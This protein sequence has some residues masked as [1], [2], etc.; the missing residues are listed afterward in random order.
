[1]L[2]PAT[3]QRLTSDMMKA[4]AQRA[5]D[6]GPHTQGNTPTW[7]QSLEIFYG[8]PT[9]TWN[10][11]QSSIELD[12][13][14]P[15]GVDNGD[16]NVTVKTLTSAGAIG[17]FDPTKGTV[18]GVGNVALGTTVSTD[19][20]V[21]YAY[22]DNGDAFIVGAPQQR[23]WDTR[24]SASGNGYLEILILQVKYIW[25]WAD[26]DSEAGSWINL[27]T[28]TGP[29]APGGMGMV[30]FDY[31]VTWNASYSSFSTWATS[32]AYSVGQQREGQG[33]LNH[34]LY[35]CTQ[36]HTSSAA[37]EPGVGANWEDYWHEVTN[38]NVLI[39]D[40]TIDYRGATLIG[41]LGGST[42]AFTGDTAPW[43][44]VV[45]TYFVPDG[46]TTAN[47]AVSDHYSSEWQVYVDPTDGYLYL[48]R[49]ASGSSSPTYLKYAGV[50]SPDGNATELTKN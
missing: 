11:S 37:D 43:G 20:I 44:G 2:Y 39:L 22:A 45:R 32:T 21:T 25:S 7:Q 48:L 6:A 26:F 41:Q 9:T 33:A 10:S 38:P 4:L 30:P 31:E 29:D 28:L 16:A 13:C 12:P 27:I 17:A 50:L 49:Y 42:V 40:N 15:S 23:L 36:A 46:A 35:E 18:A 3:G 19:A 14:D 47:L 5:E 24:I 1:M 8:K 34:R